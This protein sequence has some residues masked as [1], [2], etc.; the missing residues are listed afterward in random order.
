[1]PLRRALLLLACALPLV[2]QKKPITIDTVIAQSRARGGFGGSPVWAPDGKRFAHIQNNR[3]LLYDVASKSEKELVSLEEL[4]K[5]AVPVPSAERFDWQNR[6]V[7]ES[8]FEWSRSGQQLLLSVRGDLF[9][10]SLGSGKWEQ[11]TATPETERDPKLS[12]DGT[13]V[14]FRRAHD[15]YVLELASHNVVRLTDDGTPTLLNGELDWVY[16]EELDLGTAYWWSPDSRHIAYLQFDIAHE[17]IYPQV[18]LT[19]PRA[20]AEPERYPQAGTPNPYVHLGIVSAAGGNTH[21]MDLGD[22]R[23]ALIARVYWTPDSMKLA[24]K[25]FNRVQN[26]LDLLL[27]DAAAGTSRSILHE[28]DPYWINNNDLFAFLAGGDFIWGSERDGFQH[29]YLYGLDG[30]LRKRLTEGNWEVTELAGVDEP[31]HEVYFVSS[32]ASPLERQLYSVKLSGKERTRITQGAGTH[33]ISVSP[34]ASY[35]IDTFSSLTQ[36]S[37]R[38]IHSIDA[39]EWAVYRAADHRLTD[40]Y[41]VLPTEIVSLKN[42]TGTL[43]YGRLIKPA[44]FHA[45]EK[46]PTIVM[47]YG[48]PGAQSV[49]NAWSGANWDQVLAQR[50]FVVWQLDNRGSKGRGHSFE[51]PIYHRMGKTELA[52]QLEG[53]QYLISQGFVDPARIGMYGWS[54][55]GYMTLYSLLNSPE[56]FRA[57]IAGAPVTNWRN[58]DT[59]YT[60]RYMGLPSENGQGYAASSA[61]TYADKLQSK[62]LIVHNIEDDNVLFQNTMQ[63]AAAFERAGKLFDMVVY[64]QRTHGVGGEFQ[65]DLLEKTTDFFE[66]NLKAA[67]ER[68]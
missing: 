59:I 33:S 49:R 19:G 61:S 26:Q 43:L 27:V 6:R 30:K 44:N 18:A 32:E 31:R 5:A 45:G 9:L 35:Y 2:A 63:M 48:G 25:R 15:L 37:S 54:Y 60:E 38:T 11:L 65:R 21:W 23:D 62:L 56:I 12:P 39:T 16:P 13:R 24:V 53:I 7:S 8:S 10:F 67:D 20:I 34:D 17:M 41:E 52:D 50:G 68:H 4:Q 55:G 14:A 36:P 1:M 64:P 47:V 3:I 66:K 57:G 40:E 58:Y 51:A 28:S 22:A 42:S 46:Y 29:L